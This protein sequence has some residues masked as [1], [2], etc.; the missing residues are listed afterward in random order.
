MESSITEKLKALWDLQMVD[1]QLDEI[2]ILKGEL[3]MEVSDLEDEVTGLITR[4]EKIDTSIKDTDLEV[5]DMNVMTKEA[6]ANIV[7]YKKQLDDVKNSRE[8]DS[9]NKMLDMANLDIQLA[10]KKLKELK[11]IMDGK[12][13]TMAVTDAKLIARKKD[14]EVKKQELQSI[15]EKTEKDEEKYLKQSEKA[16]KKI[17]ERLLKAYSKIRTTYKNGVAVA[18]IERDSCGGC[19]NYVPPQLQLEIGMHKRVIACEHCG[20]ILIDESVNSVVND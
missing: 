12:K 15:I 8:F 19:F 5:Q 14:L 7:K 13:E 4:K 2:R 11:G 1:S 16:Q 17:D 20:R 6:E 3:P 9:L 10:A 18:T